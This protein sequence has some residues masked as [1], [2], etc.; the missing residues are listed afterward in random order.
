MS[1]IYVLLGISIIVIIILLYQLHRKQILDVA[2]R[3]E[4]EKEITKL[5]DQQTNLLNHIGTLER[6]SKEALEQ[7][8][9]YTRDKTQELDQYFNDLR[10]SR[11]QQLDE[12]L[13][14]RSEALNNSYQRSTEIMEIR[15]QNYQNTIQNR[16]TELDNKYQQTYDNTQLIIQQLNEKSEEARQHYESVLEPIRLLEKEKQ[17]KLYYTIQVPDE[18]KDD[19][20]FL[21]TEVSQKVSHPDVIN[22]LVWTE[23]VKPYI[24]ETFKRVGIKDEAGIYKITNID[25]NKC[26]IGKSTNL[27]KRIADHFK[28]AI[29]I[30]TI[31][32][33]A[34]HHEIWKTGF[35][36]WLIEPIIYCD[37][38]NLNSMEKYY[39]EFFDS[40]NTGYNKNAGGGG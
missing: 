34:V 4:L 33:Q 28:S 38:D 16:M 18:Y 29:G 26:Y 2:K 27:K 9:E 14:R 22:K 19:I 36:N 7:Y 21:V 25:S 15:L 12:D 35:W 39:I 1:M 30:K 20:N 11:Q 32:D 37:K 13:Q 40:Q 6:K 8:N 5:C 24:E 17:D 23:Y 10:T 3:V 31:A